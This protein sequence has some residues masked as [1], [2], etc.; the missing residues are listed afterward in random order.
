MQSSATADAGQAQPIVNRA[1]SKAVLCHPPVLTIAAR[2]PRVNTTTLATPPRPFQAAVPKVCPCL[3]ACA[4]RR[5]S[6]SRSLCFG[7]SVWVAQALPC[8]ERSRRVPVRVSRGNVALHSASAGRFGWHRHSCLCAQSRQRRAAQPR[9]AG[10]PILFYPEPAVSGRVG[11][12][13]N[14]SG[15]I[16][17]WTLAAAGLPARAR[18][19]SS[20]VTPAMEAE[21]ADRVRNVEEIVQLL[22]R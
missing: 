20:R 22:E 21:V 9:V 10:W 6:G 17:K 4:S 2:T 11:P 19:Q 13:C 14:A 7:R 1:P 18:F 15:S 16:F 3:A 5:I 12:L 8:P